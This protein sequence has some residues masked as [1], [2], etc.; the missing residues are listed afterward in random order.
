MALLEAAQTIVAAVAAGREDLTVQARSLGRHERSTPLRAA[1]HFF[2]QDE[3]EQRVSFAE[4]DGLVATIV[5][6]N[7]N[8]FAKDSWLRVSNTSL[9]SISR[10][11]R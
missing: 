6:P 11:K 10:G 8:G 9:P 5:T 3:E 7:S 4:P 1:A 2:W